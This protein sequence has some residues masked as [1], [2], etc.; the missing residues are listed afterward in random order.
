MALEQA[1]TTLREQLASALES[2]DSGAAPTSSQP[3]AGEPVGNVDK[4]AAPDASEGET[5]EQAAARLR[6]DKGRFASTPADKGKPNAQQVVADASAPAAKQRPARPSTWKK[7]Y[8]DHWEKIDPSLAEYLVQREGEFA[9]GVSTYRQK[10]TDAE[11]LVNAIAPFQQT[12]QQHGIQPAQWIQSLGHAQQVLALGT[13]EQ[14]LAMLQQVAQ[15]YNI[16]LQGLLQ[17]AAQPGADGQPAQTFDPR[18]QQL[19]QQVQ[20]LSGFV[21]NFQTREQQR[22]QEVID[23][24]LNAFR[25]KQGNEHYEQVRQ[26]MAGLLQSGLA[27]DLQSAYDAALRHPRHADIYAPIQQRERAAEEARQREAAAAA[28]RTAK[29][30]ASSVRTTTP[31]AAN[32]KSGSKDIRS[33]LSEAYDERVSGRV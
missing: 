8:W 14:K 27:D 24:E 7:D 18:V 26:T 32:G 10:W 33:Q 6:D 2:T 20:Q 9:S 29:A 12:L 1:G 3:V 31:S 30:A 5:P 28:A 17:G 15:Q 21:T 23:R 22:E 13:P 11:P 4:A 16:P 19:T 25:A